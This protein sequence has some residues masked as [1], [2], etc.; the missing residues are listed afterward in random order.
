MRSE[1]LETSWAQSER[2]SAY[3]F[4]PRSEKHDS[5]LI[6]G[7]LNE[8]SPAILIDR[9]RPGFIVLEFVVEGAGVALLHQGQHAITI[10]AY[11]LSYAKISK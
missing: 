9:R 1:I 6:F 2:A 11:A 10:P 5:G 7:A 4:L 3:F 8:V